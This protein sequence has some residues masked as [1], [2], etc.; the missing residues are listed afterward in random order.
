MGRAG[1]RPAV[2]LP[3]WPSLTEPPLNEAHR[4]LFH[5][6]REEVAAAVVDGPRGQ[7]MTRRVARA[8]RWPGVLMSEVTADAP[9]T[10]APRRG[11]A[12]PF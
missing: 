2:E 12:P 10:A 8:R 7:G 3:R 6:R 9:D 11:P 1:S 4:R 5:R